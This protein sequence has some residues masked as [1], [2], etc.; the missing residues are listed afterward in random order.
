[1]IT[2]PKDDATFD[3]CEEIDEKKM[4]KHGFLNFLKINIIIHSMTNKKNIN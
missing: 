1:M 3:F 4:K 2:E